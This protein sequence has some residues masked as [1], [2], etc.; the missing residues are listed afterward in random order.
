M[1]AALD[2]ASILTFWSNFLGLKFH[3]SIPSWNLH[4]LKNLLCSTQ[5]MCLPY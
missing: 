3:E 2:A 1:C 4:A 5:F